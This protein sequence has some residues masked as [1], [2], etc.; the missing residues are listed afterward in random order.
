M[1]YSTTNMITNLYGIQKVLQDGYIKYGPKVYFDSA[2]NSAVGK[3]PTKQQVSDMYGTIA[4][5]LY[6]Y[7]NDAKGLEG[8]K[9]DSAGTAKVYYWIAITILLI[10]LIVGMFVFYM[11]FDENVNIWLLQ[12]DWPEISIGMLILVSCILLSVYVLTF[13]NK[14]YDGYMAI[15]EK[16]YTN[17]Y[18]I[19]GENTGEQ[20]ITKSDNIDKVIKMMYN[21]NED[22]KNITV[23]TTNPML[24]YT[25]ATKR[26]M[27][28]QINIENASNNPACCKLFTETI[29]NGKKTY[30][31]K[32]DV[33][34]FLGTCNKSFWIENGAKYGN[35]VYPFV[36]TLDIDPFMLRKEI[37]AIDV[38]GQISRIREAIK[39]F[40]Q[41]MLKENDDIFNASKSGLSLENK[42]RILESIIDVLSNPAAYVKLL[43]IVDTSKAASSQTPASDC[44]TACLDDSKCIAAGFDT[45]KRVCY[46]VT[47]NNIADAKLGYDASAPYPLMVK[48]SESNIHILGSKA[49]QALEQNFVKQECDGQSGCITITPTDTRM[50]VSSTQGNLDDVFDATSPQTY[51]AGAYSYNVS[52]HHIVET[53]DISSVFTNNK[54]YFVDAIVA[55]I[56]KLDASNT[57]SLEQVDQDYITKALQSIY[58]T[59]YNLMS[60]S[61]INILSDVSKEIM[62]E[63]TRIKNDAAATSSGVNR[64][65]PYERFVDKCKTL[66]TN[67][68]VLQ[69]VFYCNELRATSKGLF[70]INDKFDYREMLN[71]TSQDL[72]K[73][74]L[75]WIPI[76]SVG[77]ILAY[78]I[79]D[80]GG[81][82]GK[83]GILEQANNPTTVGLDTVI[84]YTIIIVALAVP[85][86]LLHGYAEQAGNVNSY[87]KEIQNNNGKNVVEMSS[88][89]MNAI[90]TDTIN[91]KY[92]FV[93][94]S[95]E[96]SSN[97]S[98]FLKMP[99]FKTGAIVVDPDILK[100]KKAA[101]LSE[102]Q[103]FDFVVV[104][105]STSDKT[106]FDL[107]DNEHQL[108]DVYDS[109]VSLI[110]SYE[111]CNNLFLDVDVQVP[112]PL[113]NLALYG[114]LALIT[115]AVLIYVIKSF[116]PMGQLFK[117]QKSLN[118]INEIKAGNFVSIVDVEDSTKPMNAE[119]IIKVV[120]IILLIVFGVGFCKIISD[121]AY[122]FQNNMYTSD[123]YRNS[124]CY[125]L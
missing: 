65:V 62:V 67:Q 44:Y 19:S 37:Q 52:T 70:D 104:G 73:R 106:T 85:M 103:Y 18:P 55:A 84:K 87:N 54:Q 56:I 64:Y 105:S 109:L 32:H 35:L 25:F 17:P 33:D 107:V 77:L 79:F 49:T 27:V 80:L 40:K 115:V 12:P 63:Y 101:S 34:T 20:Q 119:N 94:S 50:M 13:A 125:D 11:W 97:D 120:I 114:G 88:R 98:D 118:H 124:Q 15:Y 29:V 31:L 83:G 7:I 58:Q 14:M 61:I 22:G 57:F 6:G 78:A 121:N 68:F 2:L 41:F 92:N 72:Y 5:K 95:F 8:R 60:M 102:M 110:E 47:N 45:T 59:K 9:E 108:K 122:E 91:K 3:K 39:F 28:K 46:T 53:N 81:F 86:F 82:F 48:Y 76:V 74:T 96:P 21:L 4:E 51:D 1:A 43:K 36:D 123:L 42:V 24:M 113:V 100:K 69:M 116:N 66:N 75:I 38:Y 71:D 26:P 111:K 90:Y 112:L 23:K 89:I 16:V 117:L 99:E 30:S 10:L 93:R